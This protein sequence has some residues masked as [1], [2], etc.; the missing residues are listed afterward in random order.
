MS[1]VD[2]SLGELLDLDLL[3]KFFDRFLAQL[4]ETDFTPTMAESQI[5]NIQIQ[6]GRGA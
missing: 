3:A 6:V 5:P 1:S 2:E 4:R